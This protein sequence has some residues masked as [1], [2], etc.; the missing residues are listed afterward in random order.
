M[1]EGTQTK[2]SFGILSK[3]FYTYSEVIQFT[4]FPSYSIR[5]SFSLV[6]RSHS[7]SSL[8]MNYFTNK[9]SRPLNNFP[10]CVCEIKSPISSLCLVDVYLSSENALNVITPVNVSY[11]KSGITGTL[12][13]KS[14][15]L[16]TPPTQLS[17][18]QI[19]YIN[20]VPS[21]LD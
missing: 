7:K 16:L 8:Y 19:L 1:E 3:L 11:S 17:Y 18:L 12:D 4:K 21:S 5:N 6:K 14:L 9:F 2:L 15:L 10:Q 13:V 20:T